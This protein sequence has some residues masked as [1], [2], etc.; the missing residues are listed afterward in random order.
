MAAQ[1]FSR[2]LRSLMSQMSRDVIRPTLRRPLNTSIFQASQRL[3]IDC[4]KPSDRINRLSYRLH[5]GLSERNRPK[6]E[7]AVIEQRVMKICK[8]HD[9][10]DGTKLLRVDS[11]LKTVSRH[12]GHKPPLTYD[13]IRERVLLVLR[14]YDKIDP[15]KLTLEA[16]FMNDL[17]LD[18]LDHV[19]VIMAMEDEFQFEIPDRDAE[20]LLRPIDIVKYVADKDEAYF[21]LQD[22]HEYPK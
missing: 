5:M 9:R 3:N 2:Q 17:G 14:L 16:H 10:I 21:E 20:K 4:F 12:Y 6:L 11:V 13:F 18:S 1:M 19:E 7:P 8:A 22:T 15:T